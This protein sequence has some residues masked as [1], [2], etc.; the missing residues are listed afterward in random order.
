MFVYDVDGDGLND[1]IAVWHCHQYGLVWYK[2]IRDAKGEITWKQNVILPPKPDLKSDDLRISQ[3]H[4]VDL[5]DMNGDG[6]KD[7]LTGK[8]FWAHGPHG[9]AEPAAP[10]VVYWFELRRDKEKG[11]RVHSPPDRRRLGRRH[12]GDRRGPQRRRD[13]R[14]D[15]GQQEGN[16]RPPQPAWQI[17]SVAEYEL[18]GSSAALLTITQHGG[19]EDTEKKS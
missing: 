10:A 14:R 3:M 2:Q 11:V 4:A 15:R 18:D 17:G 7:I 16:F 6:L 5:V 8:R 12:P 19:T 1:V 9:D 13:S